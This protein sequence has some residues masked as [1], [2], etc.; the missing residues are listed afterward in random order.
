MRATANQIRRLRQQRGLSQEQLAL[1]ADMNPAYL[2][3]IERELKCPTI[4][5][6]YKI[7]RALDLS[8][9]EFFAFDTNADV[10]GLTERFQNAVAVLP[11]DKA[12]K[13]TAIVEQFSNLLK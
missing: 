6:I 7:V 8:L 12:E 3:Q 10:S 11:A 9:P 4:D 13:I 1:K 2:G 5:T